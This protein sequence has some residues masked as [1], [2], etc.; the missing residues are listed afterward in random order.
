[1]RFFFRFLLLV[2]EAVMGFLHEGNGRLSFVAAVLDTDYGY[3]D[4]CSICDLT[5]LTLWLLEIWE[6]FDVLELPIEHRF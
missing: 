6:G 1:M 4:V 5:F 2:L 3:L